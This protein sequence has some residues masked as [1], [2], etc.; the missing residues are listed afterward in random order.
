MMDRVRVALEEIA[1][2]HGGCL[3]PEAVVAAAREP[4]HPLHEMFTWDDADAAEKHRLDQARQIIRSVRV[5]VQT[6]TREVSTVF[7]VRD[8]E[9]P[10][11]DQGYISLPRLRSDVDV[12]RDALIAEF[13]RAAAALKRAR[14]LAVALDMA[15]DIDALTESVVGLRRRAEDAPRG[16]RRIGEARA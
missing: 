7:Y 3:T 6:D 2:S 10:G 13:S 14:D 8:P 9:K 5:V 16:R 11:R 1:A 12:A 15:A 4:T